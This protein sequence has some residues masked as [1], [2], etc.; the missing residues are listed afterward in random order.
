MWI[1]MICFPQQ[2]QKSYDLFTS[3]NIYILRIKQSQTQFNQKLAFSVKH[4]LN[5]LS[6][7]LV[8]KDSSFKMNKWMF[9]VR[10]PTPTNIMQCSYQL[11]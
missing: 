3:K 2:Q 1:S 8:A 10:T 5:F 11:N 4:N 7:G 6:G 9:G